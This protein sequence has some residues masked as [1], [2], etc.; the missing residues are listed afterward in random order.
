MVFAVLRDYKMGVFL[1]GIRSRSDTTRIFQYSPTH[2]RILFL[3]TPCWCPTHRTS[4]TYPPV[5]SCAPPSKSKSK[6]NAPK[7]PTRTSHRK[8]K[9]ES[10][11]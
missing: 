9:S 5:N 8:R 2:L 4:N 7:Q 6:S 1:G 3:Y 10:S 11:H